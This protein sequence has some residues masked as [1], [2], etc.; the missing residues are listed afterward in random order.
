MVWKKGCGKMIRE[1]YNC[2]IQGMDA[3]NAGSR[4]MKEEILHLLKEEERRLPR[5]EYESYRDKAF[6]V[7]SAAEEHGFELGFCYAVRLLAE[8]AREQ[9]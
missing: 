7:A 6:L 1:L 2:L 3:P 8:C 4:R 9:V 5:Q